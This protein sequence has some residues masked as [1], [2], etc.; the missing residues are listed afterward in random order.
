MPLLTPK[1]DQRSAQDIVDELKRLIP[2][3]CPEW[4]DHNV[5]DP[6]VAL[7]EL[8]AWT[9]E[10]L[11]FQ[12]NR[13]PDLHYI[14]LMELMGMKLD[15]ARAA[16]APVTI[17]LSAP[18]P[19]VVSIGQGYEVASAR[20]ER[21]SPVIFCTMEELAIEPVKL[22]QIVRY[23]ADGKARPISFEDFAALD[24]NAEDRA[25]RSVDLF[26]PVP[27]SGD[28]LAFG[29]S[30][31]IE[32]H[33]LQ[34]QFQLDPSKGAGQLEHHPQTWPYTWQVYT[35][36]MG[37]DDG[38]RDCDCEFDETKALRFSGRVQIHLPIDAPCGLRDDLYWVRVCVATGKGKH[39]FDDSPGMKGL[40]EVRA[41]GGVVWAQHAQI[42]RDERLGVSDGT[43]GQRFTL[44]QKNLVAFSP[45]LRVIDRAGAEN[46]W[47][48]Q[49][50]FDAALQD[51]CIFTLD[52]INGEVRFAPALRL[53][54]GRLQHYGAVPPSGAEL[55]IVEYHWGGGEAGNVAAYTLDT[56]KFALPYVARVANR[57]AAL[58]GLDAES[59]E[60][61][62]LRAPT[63]LRCRD[64]AV[65]AEDFEWLTESESRL[66]AQA[67]CVV[68]QE[69]RTL[70]TVYVLGRRPPALAPP[71]PLE[72]FAVAEEELLRIEAALSIKR[73]VGTRVVVRNARLL[74]VVV[75]LNL[76]PPERG[77]RYN[78]EHVRTVLE[79]RLYRRL[80]PW[81]AIE[82]GR[83]AFRS[84][85]TSQ[86]VN[87]WLYGCPE[88]LWVTDIAL[89][90]GDLVRGAQQSPPSRGAR[91]DMIL[92][93]E[94]TVLVSAEHSV[95]FRGRI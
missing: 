78:E 33:V 16:Q 22:A 57:R 14:K 37:D 8:F 1:L 67:R 36:A 29:F 83:S 62:M 10:L 91:S 95:H 42:I 30:S 52:R 49:E 93:D 88:A 44:A 63:L 82:E 51:E 55:R 21:T 2:R 90:A 71:Y 79:G 85:L 65:T 59:I 61:A 35:G 74:P 84:M 76:E 75:R 58:P 70:I 24:D 60:A 6:G 32:R 77:A 45:T 40:P 41:M 94:G 50:R 15:P 54:D 56:P 18:Q 39:S 27:K 13:V 86:D 80:D 92:A 12:M 43:P 28:A 81:Q 73:L 72:A 26:S 89:S 38:W 66:V 68:D 9:A 4:T 25:Q 23:S 53:P 3:Y 11:L 7:I 5:S 34:F 64:R 47:R 19:K 69:D 31:K 46:T 20:S 48:E 17:W 87:H